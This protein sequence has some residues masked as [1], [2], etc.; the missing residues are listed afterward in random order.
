MSD[1]FQIIGFIF[2]AVTWL[3]NLIIGDDAPLRIVQATA[4]LLG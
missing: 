2:G 3:R 1:A 4:K